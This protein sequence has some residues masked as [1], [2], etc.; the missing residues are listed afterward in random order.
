MVMKIK[1]KYGGKIE[2]DRCSEQLVHLS[3][4]GRQYS[5][6]KEE[7]LLH[8]MFG[9]ETL[10]FDLEEAE[11]FYK[12]LGEIIEGIK[13]IPDTTIKKNKTRRVVRNG[14]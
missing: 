3:I 9:G 12:K 7:E 8:D 13:Q 2:L 1:L 14:A 4:S 11:R 6:N 10:I 5:K